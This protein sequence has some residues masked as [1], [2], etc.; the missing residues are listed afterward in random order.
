[1]NLQRRERRKGKA[2]DLV[3]VSPTQ[4]S[5]FLLKKKQTSFQR[6]SVP[7]IVQVVIP[8]KTYYLVF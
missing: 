3:K 4:T 1:M 7:N 6:S 5:F 8:L 2:T